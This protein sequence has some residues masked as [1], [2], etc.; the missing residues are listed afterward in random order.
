MDADIEVR[1]ILDPAVALTFLAKLDDSRNAAVGVV[2]Q[3]GTSVG[4]RWNDHG[5]TIV[6]RDSFTS[7]IRA[8]PAAVIEQTEYSKVHG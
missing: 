3:R 8:E 2:A 4:I 1:L 6:Q 5:A 7:G